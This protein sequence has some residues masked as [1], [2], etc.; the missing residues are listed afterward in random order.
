MKCG[1]A[2]RQVNALLLETKNC[3]C[4]NMHNVLA[5]GI[6]IQEGGAICR[7]KLDVQTNS[8]GNQY[9]NCLQLNST[10]DNVS[11]NAYFSAFV[12]TDHCVFCNFFSNDGKT[13]IS[14]KKLNILYFY[15]TTNT[16]CSTCCF[17]CSE[18]HTSCLTI[19][20]IAPGS[21]NGA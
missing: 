12:P 11:F 7:W 5:G 20:Y 6:I 1:H 19:I 2:W 13:D 17:S 18:R 3:A 14:Y 10:L 21:N 16:E 8:S 4:P 15:K 9:E